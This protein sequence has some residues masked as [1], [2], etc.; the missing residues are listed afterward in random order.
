VSRTIDKSMIDDLI[1]ELSHR[2]MGRLDQ[3]RDIGLID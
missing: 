1:I 3:P 2:W